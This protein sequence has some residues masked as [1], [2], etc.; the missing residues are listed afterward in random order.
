MVDEGTHVLVSITPLDIS[1]CD[2][3]P[4]C[5]DLQ[6]NHKWIVEIVFLSNVPIFLSKFQ[7]PTHSVS[8]HGTTVDTNYLTEPRL[9]GHDFSNDVK[10][11]V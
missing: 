3:L 7:R 5:I 4:L 11:P 2:L 10:L 9:L 6:T 1:E 8:F